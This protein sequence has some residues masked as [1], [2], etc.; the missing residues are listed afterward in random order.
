MSALSTIESQQTTESEFADPAEG[1]YTIRHHD[2][3][4]LLWIEDEVGV[5]GITKEV[6]VAFLP[7]IQKFVETGSIRKDHDAKRP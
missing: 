2:G 1:L 7:I 6:A 3:S 4:N 5:I